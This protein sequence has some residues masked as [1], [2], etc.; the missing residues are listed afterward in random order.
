L[1]ITAQQ[2]ITLRAVG[3]D[4]VYLGPSTGLR[5]GRYLDVGGKA[6]PTRADDASISH[7]FNDL[8]SHLN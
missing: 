4:R 2:G 5:T 1:L 3:D 6:R 8:L 7:L